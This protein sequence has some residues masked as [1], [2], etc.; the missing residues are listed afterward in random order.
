VAALQEVVD[1]NAGF[2]IMANTMV[3]VV[4]DRMEGRF[5]ALGWFPRLS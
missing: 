4:V 2:R 5:D 3:I 1:I